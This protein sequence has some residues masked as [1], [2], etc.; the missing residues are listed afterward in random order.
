[1]P[2]VRVVN[3][4]GP[5]HDRPGV[6]VPECHGRRLALMDQPLNSHRH[7]RRPGD[8]DAHHATSLFEAK[9]WVGNTGALSHGVRYPVS[10]THSNE[11]PHFVALLD[12][13]YI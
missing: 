3:V 6:G 7:H 4:L 9:P 13:N 8:R 5:V 1:M 10:I 12:V 11:F 2:A